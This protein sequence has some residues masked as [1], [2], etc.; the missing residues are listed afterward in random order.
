MSERNDL[1]I[2][3]SAGNRKLLRITLAGL[4]AVGISGIFT[5]GIVFQ[6]AKDVNVLIRSAAT[7]NDVAEIS[8]DLRVVS[9]RMRLAEDAADSIRV[10]VLR[11]ESWSHVKSTELDRRLGEIERRVDRIEDRIIGGFEKSPPK[12]VGLKDVLLRGGDTQ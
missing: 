11:H 10:I 9:L 7:K 6:Q 3:L 8:D 1:S 5:A 12:L 4:L 2:S